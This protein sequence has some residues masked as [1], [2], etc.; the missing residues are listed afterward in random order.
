LSENFTISLNIYILQFYF[1][2]LKTHK[3]PGR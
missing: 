1:S 2:G 3:C